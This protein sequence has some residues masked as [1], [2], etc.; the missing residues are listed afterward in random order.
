M[1]LIPNNPKT[2]TIE[3]PSEISVLWVAVFLLLVC[4]LVFSL[5]EGLTHI[6]PAFVAG[7]FA[8]LLALYIIFA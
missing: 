4:S 6:I 7:S 8:V 3:I 5:S 1:L 2:M